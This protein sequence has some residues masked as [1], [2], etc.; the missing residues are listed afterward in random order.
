MSTLPELLKK[1]SCVACIAAV[2]HA[3]QASADQP[4]RFNSAAVK[5]TPFQERNAQQN[6]QVLKAVPGTSLNGYLTR[7][8]GEGPFPAVVVLHGCTGLSPSVRETWSARLASWGY[9]VL[10]VDSFSTRGIH[11]TCDRGPLVD[12]VYDAY[13]ALEFLS[14][15]SFVDPKRI[16]LAGSSAGGTTT[17]EAVQLGGAEQ[18]MERKF[19]AAIAYY[20]NC[21]AANGDMA[22]PTLILIGELDDWNPA[23]KCQEMMAQRSGKGSAVQLDVFKGARHAFASPGLKIGTEDYGH[24]VEY[25]AAAADQSV[26]EVHAFLKKAF[27]G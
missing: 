4:V 25:N 15:Y 3:A 11:E 1:V 14:K 22:V 10:F 20:P 18:L 13:G 16:A 12:R 23:K 9:V 5:P 6:G 21:S 24:R 2:F 17:L 19:K 27:G 7:P 8:P 26:R